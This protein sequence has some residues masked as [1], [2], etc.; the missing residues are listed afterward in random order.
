[1]N[2]FLTGCEADATRRQTAAGNAERPSDGVDESQALHAIDV[3]REGMSEPDVYAV[4]LVTHA[5]FSRCLCGFS[6]VVT[7]YICRGKRFPS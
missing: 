3:L 1:M 7:Q 6:T 4:L 2:L 5:D